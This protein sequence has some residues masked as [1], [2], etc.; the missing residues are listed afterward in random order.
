M[1]CPKCQTKESYSQRH[2]A[3]YCNNCNTWLAPKCDDSS[4]FYC[5]TRPDN[6][7]DIMALS[8][9][10]GNSNQEL[11]DRLYKKSDELAKAWP[12]FFNHEE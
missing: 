8:A 5:S 1:K 4:C 6:P 7:S 11:L 10:F 2:D 3:K 9:E 12:E